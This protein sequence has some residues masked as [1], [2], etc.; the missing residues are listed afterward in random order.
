MRHWVLTQQMS[1]M[2]VLTSNNVVVY[3][4]STMCI[5]PHL[6]WKTAS[7]TVSPPR[8]LLQ[9]A[10]RYHKENTQT[11]SLWSVLITLIRKGLHST[12][13]LYLAILLEQ[14]ENMLKWHLSKNHGYSQDTKSPRMTRH[15]LLIRLYQSTKTHCSDCPSFCLFSIK[16]CRTRQSS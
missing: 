7:S 2:T 14:S 4:R 8:R 5:L 6:I 12:S 10:H 9:L 1:Y 13:S 11:S 16:W 3:H 15:T